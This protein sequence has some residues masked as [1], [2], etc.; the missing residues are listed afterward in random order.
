MNVYETFSKAKTEV[1]SRNLAFPACCFEVQNLRM[2]I[3]VVLPAAIIKLVVQHTETESIDTLAFGMQDIGKWSFCN[4]ALD[5]H[6]TA[7]R[8]SFLSIVVSQYFI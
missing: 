3:F 1:Q 2:S 4:R 6:E 8:L 7:E 5:L